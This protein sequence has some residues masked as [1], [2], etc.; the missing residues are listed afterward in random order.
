MTNKHFD[1]FA[2]N[3]T[4]K[5]KYICFPRIDLGNDHAMYVVLFD[6]VS[7]FCRM[8]YFKVIELINELMQTK[9]PIIS[10]D[11]SARDLFQISIHIRTICTHLL[12]I[13]FVGE[14]SCDVMMRTT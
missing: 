5:N 7:M 9:R 14:I 6:I 13:S 2:I 1:L 8:I 12:V 4:K 3:L 11:G 10:I